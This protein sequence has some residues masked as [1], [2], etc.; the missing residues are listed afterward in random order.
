MF[1]GS[2]TEN[3]ISVGMPPPVLE[4]LYDRSKFMGMRVPEIVRLILIDKWR[5]EGRQK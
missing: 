1:T 2:I 3:R 5:E 4:W